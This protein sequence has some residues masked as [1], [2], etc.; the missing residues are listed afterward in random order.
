MYRPAHGGWCS[1]MLSGSGNLTPAD[2]ETFKIVDG[3]L[4]LFWS[5]EFNGNAVDGLAN[6]ESKIDSRCWSRPTARGTIC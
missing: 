3:Q 5:G 6:W 4:L 2:P 1:L